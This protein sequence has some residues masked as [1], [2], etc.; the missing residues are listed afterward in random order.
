MEI[1]QKVKIKDTNTVFDGKEGIL[2]KIDGDTYTVFVDFKPEEGKKVRQNFTES[3]LED[4]NI[5][6]N[7]REKFESFKKYIKENKKF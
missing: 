7:D 4:A 3:N 2:E 5:K 1:G 6:A